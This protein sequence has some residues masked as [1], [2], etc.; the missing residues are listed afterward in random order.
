MEASGPDNGNGEK[1]ARNT[2]ILIGVLVAAVIGLGVALALV[3]AGGDDDKDKTESATTPTTPTTQTT[4]STETTITTTPPT[5][6]TTTPPE[7]TITQVQAKAAAQRAAAAKAGTF[8]ISI[9]PPEW[10]ARCT[11]AGGTDQSAS[12]SCQVAAN[13]GQCAGSVT[14]FARAPGV[15]G[16]R[17]VNVGCGE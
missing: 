13:G 17:N 11:A 9:P 8:G 14:A 10:D 16:V 2:G 3:L 1:R 5:T 15:P 4:Q 12:W 7:A 6:T